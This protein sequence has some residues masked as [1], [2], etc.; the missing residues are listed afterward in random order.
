MGTKRVTPDKSL[1]WTLE[2][3]APEP[4]HFAEA[5]QP[6]PDD[7]AEILAYVGD[8]AGRAAAMLEREKGRKGRKRGGLVSALQ[9]VVKPHTERPVEPVTRTEPTDPI[10]P[11]PA[12]DGPPAKD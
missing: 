7:P 3:S 2:G 10:S 1:R 9:D 12:P 6:L 11:D 4:A 8:D 5:A